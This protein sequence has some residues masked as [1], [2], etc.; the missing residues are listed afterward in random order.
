MAQSRE[1]GKILCGPFLSNF[2][3]AGEKHYGILWDFSGCPVLETPL[4]HTGDSG[5]I[6]SKGTR[7]RMPQLKILCSSTKI[8]HPPSE[9]E[10][11]VTL[12]NFVLGVQFD[13]KDSLEE[14]MTTHSSTFLPGEFHDRGAWQAAVQGVAKSR[15]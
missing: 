8:Q 15:T 14:G 1:K 9:K 2:K 6:P 11:I 13:Q 10:L 7:A 4:C 3:L 12:M 5:L